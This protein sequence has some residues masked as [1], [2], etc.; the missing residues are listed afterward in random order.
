VFGGGFLGLDNIS[1]VDRS[2]VESL[3]GALEQADATGWMAFFALNLTEIA[4]EL[5]FEEPI[6]VELAKHFLDRF[7]AIGDALAR[8]GGD[9]LWDPTERFFFDHLRR[10]DGSVVQLKAFS[11]AGLVPLFGTRVT[12]PELLDALP[13]FR[14]HLEKL[15]TEHPSF[16]GPCGCNLS[17]NARGQRLIALVDEHRLLPIL[18]RVLEEGRFLSAGGVRSVSRLHGDPAFPVDIDLGA[19]KVRVRYEPGEAETRVKGGNSNWRGP[20]WFPINY[21]LIQALR[22]FGRYYGP[23]VRHAM[24]SPDGEPRDFAQIADDLGRRLVSLFLPD[25]DGVARALGSQARWRAS[26]VLR[27]RLLFHEYFHGETGQGLGAS[28]QTG[29]TALVANLIDELHRPGRTGSR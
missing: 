21:L 11:I 26:P 14:R 29:W 12:D 5:A 13:E 6:Y 3:G 15:A 27:D 18:D 9:G 1:L 20:V 4:F 23:D 24:P 25:A 7:M 17:P 16:Y 28:H 8:L 10:A 22:Q 2:A 19:G